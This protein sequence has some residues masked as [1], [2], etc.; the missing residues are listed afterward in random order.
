MIAKPKK[1]ANGIYAIVLD[2]S[3]FFYERFYA[4]I[5]THCF[6]CLKAIEGKASEFPRERISGDR[7]Y[8]DHDNAF[9]NDGNTAFFCT[10][11]CKT[12]FSE[13]QHPMSEGTW[14]AKEAGQNGDIFG[15]VY[16]IYNRA[17]NVHYV[18]QTRFMLFFRWQEHIRDGSKGD[19]SDLSFSVLAQINRNKLQ[20]VDE[21]QIYLNNIEAWWLAKYTHEQH[22]VFN[23]KKPKLTLE[24][25][26][27]R[28]N[29][30]VTKQE[31]LAI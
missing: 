31:Y 22:A 29:D 17:E 5:N 4:T 26:K 18:G 19:I 25:L 20:A 2:S 28:F 13:S 1:E 21:N 7:H 6:W 30:M 10:Y 24:D 23:I 11:L 27:S 3:K 8:L 14:Q 9:S 15:Y 16:L 12:N